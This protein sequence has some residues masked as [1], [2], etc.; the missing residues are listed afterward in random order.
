MARDP[1][2]EIYER[3][4]NR[5]PPGDDA[6]DVPG[7]VHQLKLV[8]LELRPAE[9]IDPKLIPP[10][11]WLYG[12]ALVRSFVSVLVAPGGT[13]KSLWAMV[14]GVSLAT[15]IS[16]L[17]ERVYARTNVWLINLDDPM[18]ELN[19]RFAAVRLHYR[20]QPDE[21]EGRFYMNSGEE[22]GL[23]MAEMKLTED[24]FA[25]VHPDEEAL[26]RHIL[27]N[28]IGLLIVDPFAESHSLEENSNP[29]MVA[30]T[31]AWRRV[32]RRTKCAILLVHHVRKGGNGDIESAR[33]AK[34][35]TDSARV[36]LVMSTM[37]T[38]E[39]EALGI[40][41]EDRLSYVRLDDAKANLAPR[42]GAARWFKLNQMELGNQTPEYPEGDQVAVMTAWIPPSPWEGLDAV[43]VN[44][45]LDGL[46]KGPEDGE[47][48][49]F[50]RQAKE[51]WAGNV[52]I[53]AAGRTPVQAQSMLAVWK[54][55]QVIIEN[56][57]IS[58]KR[59]NRET[60]RIVVNELVASQIRSGSLGS[61]FS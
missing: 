51:R 35:L 21:W 43:L 24:G 7:N 15:G 13:G 38:E 8:P 32:A 45:I 9:D 41:D 22:R 5:F 50:N 10:R 54:K 4:N 6:N 42:A 34:A 28:A 14:A 61:A 56:T 26:E 3:N 31:A 27:D 19:R 1:I 17:G 20:L 52:I 37:S 12:R 30:A 33:G 58:P 44:K 53:E 11:Q 25:V 29:Q 36:G 59:K 47:F 48:W 55:N 18:D 16:L 60:G 23:F 57:Y 46:A 39:A 2:E 49:S 40:E